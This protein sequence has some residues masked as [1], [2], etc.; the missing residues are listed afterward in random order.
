MKTTFADYQHRYTAIRMEREEGIL[1]LALHT[2]GDS[3]VW[4][5][6][7]HQELGDAFAEIAA[8]EENKVVILRGTGENFCAAGDM[9]AF[10]ELLA[11]PS[12]WVQVYGEGRRLYENLLDI[13]VPMVGVVN[14]PA[15]GHA[16][17][18]LLCDIVIGS[19]TASFRDSHFEGGI[20]PGDGVHLVWPLL[21]GLNRGR[22]FVLTGSEISADEALQLGVLNEIVSEPGELLPRAQQLA[23]RLRRAPAAT[24][25]LTRAALTFELRRVFREYLGY[26]LALEG[27]AAS[28]DSPM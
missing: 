14:G 19:P 1:E 10:A 18:A 8:D 5:P 20:V 4:S 17:L 23:H 3:L 9:P 12:G 28:A 11:T 15:Y 2:Q 26:G 7:A 21:L 16:Q 27:L 25:R 13:P 6:T 22:Y 24:L